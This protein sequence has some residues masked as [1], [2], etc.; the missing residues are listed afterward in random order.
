MRVVDPVRVER[1]Y[2]QSIRARPGQV[3]PLLCP[4]RE[5]EWVEGWDPVAVY[6]RSGLAEQDC[7]FVT[8]DGRR[9]SIWMITRRD[10]ENFRLEMVKVTPGMTV[11]KV[12]ITLREDG[13][14]FT[15]AVITYM[16]TALSE[17]GTRFVEAYTEEYYA[18]FMGYWE[19]TLND[20]LGSATGP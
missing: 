8:E 9:E 2:V 12:T 18:E 13:E 11:G 1:T 15:E 7:I 3:F 16:Y 6:S 5:K 10:L 17:E 20:F 19:K 4:V 14:G